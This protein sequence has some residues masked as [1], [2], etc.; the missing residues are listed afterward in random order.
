MRPATADGISFHVLLERI[1]LVDSK[2]TLV[3]A[4]SDAF[5]GIAD[6]SPI[7][8]DFFAHDADALVSPANSFG[9]MDGGLDLAIRNELGLGIEQA[10]QAAIRERHHGELPVGSAEVVATGHARW[11]WLVVAPTMRYPED[12]SSTLNAYLAFRA[13]LLAVERHNQLAGTAPIRTLV[14][15]GLATGI[16]RLPPARCAAQMRRAFD[17]AQGQ[18]PTKR[19][20]ST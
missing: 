3:G 10:V 2:S 17:E 11:P 7:Q 12:V 8:G 13:A 16:G 4:W 14:C 5:A 18:L 19:G 1:L 20:L 15:P 6:V 9:Y